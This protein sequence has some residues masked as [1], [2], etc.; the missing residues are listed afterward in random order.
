[1]NQVRENNHGNSNVT[2][3]TKA[4][5]K[6]KCIWSKPDA[7]ISFGLQEVIRGWTE[8]IPYFLK[9]EEVEL[10]PS[11]LGYGSTRGPFGVDQYL[12]FDIK[13]IKVN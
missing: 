6:W 10:I 1:M 2:V 4:L 5:Y 3:A 8:G 13:L 12:F 9:K 7:G 11:S